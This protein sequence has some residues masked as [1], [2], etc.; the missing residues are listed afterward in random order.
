MHLLQ[1]RTPAPLKLQAPGQAL[2]QVDVVY[3][4]GGSSVRD[5]ERMREVA[6]IVCSFPEHLPC[7]V[8]SAMG[9]TTNMLL[10]CGELAL[11]CHTDQIGS[12]PPLR[13]IRD[14][15]LA[16][17]AE[18]GVEPPVRAEV[19]RLLNELQQLLIG[20]N[21]MQDLTARAKD[22]L[23][24]FGERMATRIFA[25]YL[26]SQGVPARQHDAWDLGFT[27][28]D[29]FGNGDIIYDDTL[30]KV[31]AAL[32]FKPGAPRELPIV[33]GFLA[34]AKSSRAITTLGRG[35]SDLSATVLGAALQLKEVQV[36]KDVDGV[37]SSDPRIVKNTR[38]VTELTFEEATEL[39]YFGAQVLHPLAM[40]PAIRCGS[41]SVRVKNSYNRT[42]PG[43]VITATRDLSNTVVTSIVLKPNVTMVD[44]HST[45]MLGAH[46]FLS[47]VFDVFA[48][49]QV[50][51][52]VVATSEV[53]VS[54]TLDPKRIWNDGEVDEEIDRLVYDLER[55]ATASITRDAAIV[56]LICNVSRTSEILQR[57]FSVL[58]RE[59]ISVSMMS[60][61]ASKVNISLVIDAA[62]GQRAVKAL[63]EE[64]FGSEGCGCNG[65]G[66]A[67]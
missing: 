3:K 50:S 32:T 21:I 43:S 11:S 45:R 42:A 52:D 1:A 60:Q 27:T 16:T 9:K 20:I 64:F 66:A 19:E 40:Q 34:K 22:S 25:S 12:L 38:P 18:L 2:S 7:V 46:G 14:L 48:R 26:R 65:D 31:C 30:P 37:L 4:F 8:L 35:G 41:L 56:S 15:H 44:I 17:C 62:D 33:T 29:N 39:A 6:D 55:I 58:L 59:G 23:V 61:G 36:W 49:H 24:S 67:Q 28:D 63:H 13:A 47:K 51:V 54:L 5:A 53:S 57:S 10:E